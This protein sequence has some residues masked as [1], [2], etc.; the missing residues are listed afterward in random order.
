MKKLL[1]LILPI[2]FLAACTPEASVNRRIEKNP[3]WYGELSQNQQLL[4]KQG[5]VEEGMS[6]NAV[7][8]AWGPPDHVRK[9]RKSGSDIETWIYDDYVPHIQHRIGVSYGPG[10]GRYGGYGYGIYDPFWGLP[11]YG[12]DVHYSRTPTA[13]AVFRNGRVVEWQS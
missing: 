13:K 10:W 6:K 4:V 7:F 8:L 9:G 11:Y 1:L 3:E 12:H 2:A 5:R